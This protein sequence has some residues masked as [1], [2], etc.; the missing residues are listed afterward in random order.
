MK[1]LGLWLALTAT[2]LSAHA[3]PHKPDADKT[4]RLI[5]AASKGDVVSIRR[6]I[7][8][9][10][11]PNAVSKAGECALGAAL[12]KHRFGTADVLRK[13]GADFSHNSGVVL[14]TVSQAD[15]PSLSYILKRGVKPDS[16]ADLRGYSLLN[17]VTLLHLAEQAKFSPVE[18]RAVQ[19]LLEA[20]ADPNKLNEQGVSAMQD[21][22]ENA[23][24]PLLK[25]LVRFGGDA[26]K[27]ASNSDTPLILIIG[28]RTYG[29]LEDKDSLERHAVLLLLLEHGAR[30]NARDKRGVA[31]I[32]VAAAHD[33]VTAIG[34]LAA[35]G[36]D[37]NA[38]GFNGATPLHVAMRYCSVGA[39]RKLLEL[40]ADASLRDSAGRSVLDYQH[41]QAFSP[42]WELNG[43]SE[44][45]YT[46][47][48]E[49]LKL[50]RAQIAWL[51]RKHLFPNE[52][53][54]YPKAPVATSEQTDL[55]YN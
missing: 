31:P 32:H 12:E 15:L 51:I 14:E 44:K 18:L 33:F 4:K 48:P 43:Q 24:L 2:A 50:P 6:L 25:L 39:A 46:L 36:A 22:V 52:A 29:E 49:D 53:S 40:G 13:L 27:P 20:G 21:A 23:D 55:G 47:T 38:R 54:I 7:R 1:H 30:V 41:T 9:G 42:D 3:A 34:D 45:D 19:M 8:A 35:H 17:Y 16:I 26:N 10:A 28:P 11:D 5:Q 37:I